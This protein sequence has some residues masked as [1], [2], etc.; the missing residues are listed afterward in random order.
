MDLICVSLGDK[1]HISLGTGMA[2][3]ISW[4]QL[5][6]YNTKVGTLFWCSNK[7]RS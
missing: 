3:E 6:Q 7:P 4:L 1:V 2:G 5:I